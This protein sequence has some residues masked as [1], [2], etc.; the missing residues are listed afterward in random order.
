M[1]VNFH[2]VEICEPSLYIPTRHDDYCRVLRSS[3][4]NPFLS[5]L[6]IKLRVTLFRSEVIRINNNNKLSS[7]LGSY[8]PQFMRIPFPY[9]LFSGL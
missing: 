6:I 9:P 7:L 8:R 2:A 5:A 4:W 3:R 1:L